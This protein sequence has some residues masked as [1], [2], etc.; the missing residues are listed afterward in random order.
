MYF[1]VDML[2][3]VANINDDYPGSCGRYQA[4]LIA[5]GPCIVCL[6]FKAQNLQINGCET[7]A[8]ANVFPG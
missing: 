5:F 6:S 2:S 7:I 8:A 4:V 1:L 3:A